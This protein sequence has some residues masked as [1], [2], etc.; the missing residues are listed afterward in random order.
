MTAVR[1]TTIYPPVLTYQTL[2]QS[3]SLCYLRNH[4]DRRT[5]LASPK[6]PP[7]TL[8]TR[9]KGQETSHRIGE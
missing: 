9:S 4:Y 7:R 1:L 3:H 8:C 6:L 5:W 2:L